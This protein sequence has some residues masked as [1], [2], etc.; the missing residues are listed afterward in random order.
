MEIIIN[1]KWIG[2]DITRNDKPI[3][4]DDIGGL[5]Y[6]LTNYNIY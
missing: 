6:T 5:S 2:G 4:P 1:K 3:Y